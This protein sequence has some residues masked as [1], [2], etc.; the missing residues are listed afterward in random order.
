M[1]DRPARILTTP[2][3]LVATGVLAGIVALTL[4]PRTIAWPARTLLLDALA[5]LPARWTEVLL[6]GGPDL[7]LNIAFYVP[8]GMALA[9][10]LPLRWSP[11]SVVIGAVVSVIVESAQAVIPG[12]VPDPGDVLANTVGALVGTILVVVLRTIAR[13]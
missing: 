12:R 5:H 3:V 8:L 2:R 11:A 4:A 10:L 1:S 13:R 6:S 7:A 9:L